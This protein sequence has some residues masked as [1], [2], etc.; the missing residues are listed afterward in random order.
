[1]HARLLEHSEFIKHSGLQ[2]GG[3]P[4]KLGRQEQDGFPLMFLHCEFK[5]HGDGMQGSVT[6]GI[7]GCGGGAIM[8][9]VIFV[10]KTYI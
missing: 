10:L 5:P 6:I 9:C 8:F 2:L 3:D 7:G 4:I 1:M